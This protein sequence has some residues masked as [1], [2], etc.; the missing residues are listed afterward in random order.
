M[1]SDKGPVTAKVA[2]YQRF[3]G[4]SVTLNFLKIHVN[5]A[6]MLCIRLQHHSTDTL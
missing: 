6:L 4:H 1:K 3:S 5:K 2:D